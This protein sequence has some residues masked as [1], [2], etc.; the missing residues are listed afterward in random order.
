MSTIYITKSWQS[1]SHN[2]CGNQSVVALLSEFQLSNAQYWFLSFCPIPY[3]LRVTPIVDILAIQEVVVDALLPLLATDNGMF[4]CVGKGKTWL[5]AVFIYT[6]ICYGQTVGF[7]MK[8][9]FGMNG[10]KRLVHLEQQSHHNVSKTNEL[11][12]PI[13]IWMVYSTMQ[14]MFYQSFIFTATCT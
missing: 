5:H 13:A 7:V 4:T 12:H 1:N 2:V 6:T 8:C 11:Q 3:P 9:T 14:C 10:V